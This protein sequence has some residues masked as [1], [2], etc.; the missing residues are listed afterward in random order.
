M[1][2]AAIAR[3]LDA[4]PVADRMAIRRRM[5]LSGA[6]LGMLAGAVLALFLVPSFDTTGDAMGIA[7]GTTG[8]GLGAVLGRTAAF[9]TTRRRLIML[10]LAA[11]VVAGPSTACVYS[12]AV[13]F[14][15]EDGGRFGLVEVLVMSVFGVV[16]LSPVLAMIG[17]LV[18]LG[19]HVTQRDAVSK[20]PKPST[21]Y[22]DTFR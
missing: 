1:D 13:V 6:L 5:M 19:L 21:R 11:T 2:D 17:V 14:L 22:I 10:S 16:L 18:G 7:L 12:V 4:A 9:V 8:A 3:G 20:L 15:A